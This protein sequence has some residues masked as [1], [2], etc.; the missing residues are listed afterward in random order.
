MRTNR[1]E[2]GK[3]LVMWNERII[4]AR[5]AKL[6]AKGTPEEK[7]LHRALTHAR[8][9]KRQTERKMRFIRIISTCF[10]ACVFLTGCNT[11]REIGNYARDV[12]AV[13]GPAAGKVVHAFCN[14]TADMFDKT[15][16]S[17]KVTE[18]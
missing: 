3:L 7:E 14:D 5:N 18:Q 16:N 11:V 10:I 9:R 12:F 15:S 1:S 13:S 6:R 17:N 4:W 8:R 2:L